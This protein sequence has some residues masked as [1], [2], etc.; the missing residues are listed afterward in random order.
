LA[1]SQ[2]ILRASN[3]LHNQKNGKHQHNRKQNRMTDNPSVSLPAEQV[4]N[5]SYHYKQHSTK[6]SNI[7]QIASSSRTC[8]STLNIEKNTQRYQKGAQ[9]RQECL[10]N[11]PDNPLISLAAAAIYQGEQDNQD[12]AGDS[13]NDISSPHMHFQ[14]L[15]ALQ[16]R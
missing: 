14:D 7:L 16:S 10:L 13:Y 1:Q 12:K 2:S 4:A 6:D 8:L 11:S 5:Y 15:L 9:Q 3:N